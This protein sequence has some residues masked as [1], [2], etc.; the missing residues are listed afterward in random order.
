[1]G[2]LIVGACAQAPSAT[3]EP[4]ELGDPELL[5]M[6]ILRISEEFDQVLLLGELHGALVAMTRVIP[7]EFA[8]AAHVA[9]VGIVVWPAWRG[10]GIGR[11]MLEETAR[12]A[13]AKPDI[14]RLE[15]RIAHDDWALRGLAEATGW[16]MERRERGALRRDGR[17]LDLLIYVLDRA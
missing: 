5:G 15:V 3:Y 9:T 2:Q 12:R 4:D 10:R 8:Y 11:A 14:E 6:D 13:F 16:V 7:R 17:A 1:M